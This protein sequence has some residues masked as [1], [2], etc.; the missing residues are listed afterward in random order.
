MA[1]HSA[2][3]QWPTKGDLSESLGSIQQGRDEIFQDFVDRLLKAASRILG[4][5]RI[6]NTFLT[7][8][9]YENANSAWHGTIRPHKGHTDLAGFIRLCAEIGPL[10]NQ[11]LALA[12]ALQGTTVQAMLALIWGN[13]VCFK[14]GGLGHFKNDCPRN[15]G[16]K[17]RQSGYAPGVCPRCRK[18]NHWARVCKSKSDILGHPLP[19]N[20][21]RGQ[22]QAL[23]YPQQAAYGAMKLLPSQRNP[24]LN[25]SGQPQEVQDWTSVPPPT[26]Y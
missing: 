13:K 10:Y 17:N 15:R 12:T 25:L 21:R 16:A 11:G 3:N 6:R 8:L 26:Q 7:Q 18:G 1:A 14:C 9:A 19:G 2:W 5:S 24:F 4:D 22:P 20:E 23:K